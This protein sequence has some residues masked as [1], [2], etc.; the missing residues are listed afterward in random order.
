MV[1]QVVI[2][3]AWCQAAAGVVSL[4][5]VF[6]LVLLH[7]LLLPKEVSYSLVHHCCVCMESAECQVLGK[8]KGKRGLQLFLVCHGTTCPETAL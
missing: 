5:L 3:L 1:L 2:K 4:T 8:R 6:F 7:Q